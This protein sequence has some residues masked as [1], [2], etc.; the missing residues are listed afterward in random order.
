MN[1]TLIIILLS[2]T[3]L[4]A[5]AKSAPVENPFT[6]AQNA[7]QR[8]DYP[9]AIDKYTK[10]LANDKSAEIYY[11]RAFAYYYMGDYQSALNDLNVAIEKK[12][13]FP[14]AYNLRGL[15]KS[16]VGNYKGAMEDYDLAI[17]TDPK[18]AQA[19]LNRGSLYS[20]SQKYDSAI[21]D[22]NKADKYSSKKNPY[23]HMQR[24][25]AYYA[26]SR[27]TAA[28][29][30]FSRAIKG[31][32]KFPE[33]YYSRANANFRLG[34][35]DKA[36]EDY[37][38]TIKLD[39]S[40]LGALNNRALAYEQMGDSVAAAADR[41]ELRRLQ[42]SLY[43]PID[44]MQ[45]KLMSD[46]RNTFVIPM[47]LKWVAGEDTTG[48]I[49]ET[50]IVKNPN[51]LKGA[52][53]TIGVTAGAMLKAFNKINADNDADLVAWWKQHVRET[54]E[55]DFKF[56]MLMDK[57]LQRKGKVAALIMSEKQLSPQSPLLKC[58]DYVFADSG[59]IYYCNMQSPAAQWDYYGIIFD[60]MIEGFD[61]APK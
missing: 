13:K 19:Y 2:L 27:Y 60:K 52:P 30:D 10:M 1:K 36:V 16:E 21:I 22:L 20:S 46:S 51:E 37:D 29:E 4:Y 14:D 54:S 43:E 45:F 12:K 17:S 24:G 50:L 49:I 28:I 25:K 57:T 38:V 53:L 9:T 48:G 58:Y 5:T 42:D 44:K 35:F 26:T 39:S 55:K 61:V 11:E 34:K 18:F 6:A 33:I 8:G 47:P 3:G 40:Y 41:A 7:M 32:L 15:I 59:N 56:T 31:G 23:V